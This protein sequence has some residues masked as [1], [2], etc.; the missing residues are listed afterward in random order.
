MFCPLALANGEYKQC[1]KTGCAWWNIPQYL[2]HQGAFDADTDGC[3][4]VV[5]LAEFAED[6]SNA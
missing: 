2:R 5:S 1:L 4:A 3:C 6:I